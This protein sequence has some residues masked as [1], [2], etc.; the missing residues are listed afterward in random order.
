MGNPVEPTGTRMKMQKYI[1][2][3]IPSMS[4]PFREPWLSDMMKR[5]IP[6]RDQS[7]LIPGAIISFRS[8]KDLRI[9]NNK[10]YFIRSITG[11]EELKKY[12]G[13]RY[14]IQK[15]YGEFLLNGAEIRGYY[16]DTGTE[17]QWRAA[18]KQR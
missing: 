18:K 6:L 11:S 7:S 16:V 12:G 8:S 9:N 14:F 10:L 4:G 2:V 1:P 17:S 15:F 3:I 5:K 13:S